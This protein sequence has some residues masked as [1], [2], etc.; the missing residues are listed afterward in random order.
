MITFFWKDRFCLSIMRFS[1]K[2]WEVNKHA[3]LSNVFNLDTWLLYTHYRGSSCLRYKW[4]KITIHKTITTQKR[5]VK[6]LI[7]NNKKI[8]I[9]HLWIKGYLLNICNLDRSISF[10]TM[11][12]AM[13]QSLGEWIKGQWQRSPT[14]RRKYCFKKSNFLKKW[15]F[16]CNLF[17]VY[18]LINSIEKN[19]KRYKY[20]V[21]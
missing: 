17:I 1:L 20:T 19:C 18:N 11:C 9:I 6:L 15:Y 7:P 4:I 21:F 12:L 14:K 8:G 3:M 10:E 5:P 13:V 2:I 16:I